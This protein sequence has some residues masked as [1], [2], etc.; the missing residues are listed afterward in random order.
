MKDTTKNLYHERMLTVLLHIQSH[1]DDELELESLAAM[2]FFSPV[3]FH[4]IFKGMMGETVVEHI[5]RIRL[6]RAAIKLAMGT[7]SVT[8]AA[9]DAGYEAVESF[10]RRFKKMFGCPPSTYQEQHWEKIYEKL[11]GTIHYRPDTTRTGLAIQPQEETLMD[12]RFVN[13]EPMRVAFVRHTGPYIECEDTWK[14]LCTWASSKGLLR[15]D[16]KYIGVS[17]DDPQVTP[18][19]K[20]RYDAC[21]TV[22]ENV[23]GEGKIGIQ[24]IPG[25]EYAVT[26]HAGPYEKLEST[27]AELMGQWLLQSGREMGE[28]CFEIYLNDPDSTPPEKLLTD[29][30]LALK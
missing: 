30:Y 8:D 3:H 17:H 13:I 28:A 24:T 27:Y 12:V 21:I 2:T 14:T 18:P 11:P 25:G 10:S 4:R 15:M 19:E 6:E 9:F 16:A 22:E 23:E 29:I 7:S 1:L 5:R 20:L 26:T